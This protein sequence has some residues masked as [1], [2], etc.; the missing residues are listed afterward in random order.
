MYDVS[1]VYKNCLILRGI[2]VSLRVSPS[3]NTF[4]NVS[5]VEGEEGPYS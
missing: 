3:E 5:F 1:K 2:P 4:S